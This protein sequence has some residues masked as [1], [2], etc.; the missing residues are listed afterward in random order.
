M[1]AIILISPVCVIRETKRKLSRMTLGIY[2][3]RRVGKYFRLCGPNC[4]PAL[5]S[6]PRSKY[7]NMSLFQETFN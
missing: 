6:S 1:I 5:Q 7:R 4:L 3:K 2:Y